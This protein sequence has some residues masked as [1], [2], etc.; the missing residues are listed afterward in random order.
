MYDCFLFGTISQHSQL[1][2]VGNLLLNDQL[3]VFM[4]NILIN[5]LNECLV[6]FKY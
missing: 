6:L 1:M 3:I 4:V 5:I 2:L